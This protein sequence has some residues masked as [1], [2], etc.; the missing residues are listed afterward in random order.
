[1]G[2]NF[3][4]KKYAKL[5][6]DKQTNNRKILILLISQKLITIG[7]LNAY[8]YVGR[9]TQVKKQN[10]CRG[11][12]IYNFHKIRINKF[13]FEKMLICN[14]ISNNNKKKILTFNLS[15]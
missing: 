6:T 9:R 11:S 2:L 3:P 5:L 1:M 15:K 13:N 10:L 7:R 4:A 8:V 14:K 12:S